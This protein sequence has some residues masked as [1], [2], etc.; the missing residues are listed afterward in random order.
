MRDVD[1]QHSRVEVL[2]ILAG[3]VAVGVRGP[4]A[5]ADVQHAV[6]PE[7]HLA[8][9][10][11]VGHP[12]DD[13]VQARGIAFPVA[14]VEAEDLVLLVRLGPLR[15]VG[16]DVDLVR[17][18]VVGRKHQRVDPEAL[19]LEEDLGLVDGRVVR[20][21]QDAAMLQRDHGAA[22]ARLEGQVQRIPEVEVGEGAPGLVGERR[23]GRTGDARRGPGDAAFGWGGRFGFR[24]AGRRQAEQDQDQRAGHHPI[25][26]WRA[27]LC[28]H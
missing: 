11:A 12:L 13:E 1:A 18:R 20:K 26:G 8:A 16:E 17:P 3:D 15:A 7:A 22:G 28:G 10:M 21:R 19:E 4:V 2:E 9:V 6:G 25:Y 24:A 23:V 27:P 5:G 14:D